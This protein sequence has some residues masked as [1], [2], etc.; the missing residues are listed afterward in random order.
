MSASSCHG[1]LNDSLHGMPHSRHIAKPTCPSRRRR[2]L[3][4]TRVHAHDVSRLAAAAAR[5][6]VPLQQSACARARSP[7]V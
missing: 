4:N 5:G 1:L 7:R 3:T 6:P 2:G